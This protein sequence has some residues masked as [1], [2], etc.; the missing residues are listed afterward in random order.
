MITKE[1]IESRIVKKPFTPK[2]LNDFPRYTGIPTG[3][4]IYKTKLKDG[5][6][7]EYWFDNDDDDGF[8]ICLNLRKNKDTLYLTHSPLHELIYD[9]ETGEVI[10]IVDTEWKEPEFIKDHIIFMLD[11]VCSED[12]EDFYNQNKRG[13]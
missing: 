12:L 1:Y 11:S 3:Q 10:D 6:Y 2:F 13:E 8:S 7:L 5:F 9:N 4:V